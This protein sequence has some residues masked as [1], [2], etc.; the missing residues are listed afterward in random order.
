MDVALI[1]IAVDSP[2]ELAAA[3]QEYGIA[4]TP[5]LTDADASV[6]EA[7]DVMQWA[8]P[9]GE[10]SHTFVLV[11]KDGRIIWVQDYG[12]PQNRG[13]MYVEPSELTAEIHSR[14]G[15]E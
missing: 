11:N 14:L 8:T 3:A 2:E 6:A 10:P 12:S 15:T 5:L 13:V 7:Y 9:S 4:D 1:S